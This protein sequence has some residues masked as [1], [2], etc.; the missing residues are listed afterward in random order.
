MEKVQSNK[1]KVINSCRRGVK[2]SPTWDARILI[3]LL[4]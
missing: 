3:V 4:N 1:T 2:A